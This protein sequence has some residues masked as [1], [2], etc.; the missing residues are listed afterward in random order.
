MALSSLGTLVAA[1]SSLLVLYHMGAG[2]WFRVTAGLAASTVIATTALLCSVMKKP[3]ASCILALLYPLAGLAF[4]MVARR[5]WGR[6]SDECKVVA[7]AS[8]IVTPLVPIAALV[9]LKPPIG[10][11]VVQEEE[12]FGAAPGASNAAVSHGGG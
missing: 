3:R 1:V 12:L 2:V 10:R 11:K 6:A 5:L 9:C 4:Y 8:I 7:M